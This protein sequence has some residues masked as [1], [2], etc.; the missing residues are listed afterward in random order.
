MATYVSVKDA[1]EELGVSGQT[2]RNWFAWGILKGILVQ[3]N[4]SAQRAGK[5]F[6]DKASIEEAIEN[7]KI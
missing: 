5:L 3:K 1:A 7:G 2:V 6:I 4:P